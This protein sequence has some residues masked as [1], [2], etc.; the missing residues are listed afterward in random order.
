MLFLD[1]I[2]TPYFLLLGGVGLIIAIAI[3]S[4]IVLTM[5]IMALFQ[6]GSKEKEEPKQEDNTAK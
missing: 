2:S 4:L 5:I 1:V 3:G 6:K